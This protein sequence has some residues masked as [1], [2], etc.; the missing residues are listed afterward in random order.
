MAVK[1]YSESDF[2]KM[3]VVGKMAAQVLDYIEEFVKPG[4][5]TL[6]INDLCHN[7]IIEMGAIPAPLNYKGFPKSICTSINHVVC[8]GIPKKEDILHQ[9][10]INGEHLNKSEVII[11]TNYLNKKEQLLKFKETN[12]SPTGI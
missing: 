1:I 10:K 11:L 9:R 6:E 4:V 8:H 3:S 12:L 5:S 7:K 2:E